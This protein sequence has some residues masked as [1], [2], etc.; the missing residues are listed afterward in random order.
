MSDGV[1]HRFFNTRSGIRIAA[2][3]AGPADG[4]IVL[5]LHG[6]G[7]TRHSWAAALTS[8]A[9]RGLH[10]VSLDLRGH[11]DSGWSTEGDY[12]LD[13]YIGDACDVLRV[14][15]APAALVGASLGGFISLNMAAR[16]D[17]RA[18]ALVL[19]DIV[20]R[21]EKGGASEI[22]TF[23]RAHT[24]GFSSIERAMEV[25]AAYLPHRR[26]PATSDGLR[27]NLRFRDGRYYWHW[28]PAILSARTGASPNP[29]RHIEAARAISGMPVMLIHG[30][31][32]RVVSAEGVAEFRA[33]VPDAEYVRLADA[34]HMVAG[35][36]ND[37]FNAPF[38]EFLTRCL[39]VSCAA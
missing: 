2:S 23:M 1:R 24:D 30:A 37:S 13:A 20:P 14:K 21:I 26:R 25:V 7:Q 9:E 38:V 27:K 29:A 4:P 5:L 15:N 22:G 3:E 28:D 35:D 39:D 33:I 16:G 11:G 34:D 18:T 32:S 6:S 19:V 8:L 10:A 31:H 12:G 36:A 17:V